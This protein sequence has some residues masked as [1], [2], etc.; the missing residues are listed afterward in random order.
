MSEVEIEV[1]GKKEMISINP[2]G[3]HYREYTTFVKKLDEEFK[4]ARE[5]AIKKDQKP[6]E[7]NINL[8]LIGEMQDFPIRLI[9]ES[10]NGRFKSMDE[11]YALPQSEI[12]KLMKPLME[13][14]NMKGMVEQTTKNLLGQVKLEGSN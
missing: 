8:D 11:V 7:A 1:S 6:D 10:S 14:L 9:A 5:E 13:I 2:L 4:R 12:N 3:R